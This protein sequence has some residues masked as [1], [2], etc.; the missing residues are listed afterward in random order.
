MDKTL[1]FWSL[2]FP[3]QSIILRSVALVT[4]WTDTLSLL[5]ELRRKNSDRHTQLGDK[6]SEEEGTLLDTPSFLKEF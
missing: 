5:I 6:S 1:P 3:S 4:G 2:I